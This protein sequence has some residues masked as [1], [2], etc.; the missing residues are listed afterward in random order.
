MTGSVEVLTGVG[1]PIGTELRPGE[2]WREA[3]ERVAAAPV[4]PHDLA[5][6][7]PRFTT[8]DTW[9]VA[10]RPATLGDLPA[11]VRWRQHEHVHRWWASDGAPTPERVRAQYAPEIAGETPTMLWI[12]EVNG[13]SVGFLQDYRL[14][15]YPEYAVLTPDPEAIGVDYAIGEPGWVGRGVGTCLLWRW[16]L[17]LHDRY[18]GAATAFAAPDHRNTA[19]LRVL[20]KVGFRSGTWFD[21]PQ[22]DGSVATVVGC[23]LH[24]QRVLGGTRQPG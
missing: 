13:R 19:S 17:S 11:L 22:P 3:A 8:A 21:E 6:D 14:R 10:L 16:L 2:S 23:T 7:P 1:A 9:Q 15:D 5:A 18:P 24:L 4:C 12:V 20:A